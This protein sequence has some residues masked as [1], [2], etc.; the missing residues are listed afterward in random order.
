M[1]SLSWPGAWPVE[2]PSK[3]QMGSSLGSLGSPFSHVFVL[4]R[5]SWPEPPIQM[6]SSWMPFSSGTS[7][8]MYRSNTA[9]GYSTP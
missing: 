8:D 6:Y 4:E 1:T 2:L 3:F 7:S 9:Q 5:R